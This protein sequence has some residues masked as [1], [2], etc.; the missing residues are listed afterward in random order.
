MMTTILA[1]WEF[2]VYQMAIESVIE[3]AESKVEAIGRHHI[4]L[5]KRF[6][7]TDAGK[8]LHFS[9]A[10]TQLEYFDGQDGWCK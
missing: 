5:T 9:S 3:L 7:R 1:Y 8:Q 4:F 2:I 10:M 6:N